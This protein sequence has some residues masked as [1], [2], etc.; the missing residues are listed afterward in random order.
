MG[1]CMGISKIPAE[2]A[3]HG[4]IHTNVSHAK[5]P[6]LPIRYAEQF[7]VTPRDGSDFEVLG[8]TQKVDGFWASL[9]RLIGRKGVNTGARDGTAK[10][11]WFRKNVRVAQWLHWHRHENRFELFA[12]YLAKARESQHFF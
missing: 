11:D 10:R 6:G 4:Y 2:F 8:G 12:T 7:T 9:R 3:E 5:K 1:L